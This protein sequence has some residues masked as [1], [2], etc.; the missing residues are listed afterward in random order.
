MPSTLRARLAA[1]VLT[2]TALTTVGALTAGCS[3]G[4]DTGPNI[5]RGDNP[6]GDQ[7]TA[8]RQPELSV[9]TGDLN[10]R[11]CDSAI[12][13]AYDMAAPSGVTV[14]CARYDVPADPGGSSDD[15]ISIGVMKATTKTTPADAPP[16][17]LTSGTDLPSSRTLLALASGDGKVLL[18][19]QPVVAVDFRGTGLGATVD[20]LSSAQR[21]VIGSGAA[22]DGRD[23]D[24]RITAVGTAA[25]AGADLC[26]D[27]LSPNQLNYSIDAAAA[28]IEGL[29][30]R[31]NV[32]RIALLG[33]GDGSS[34]ALRYAAAH[35]DHVGRLI[36][37]SPTGYNV[38]AREQTAARARGVQKTLT[39]FAQ[40]CAGAGCALG[41]DGAA[42]LTRVIGAG[43][44][45][46]L[47]G[48]SDVEV[49]DAVTTAI[50]VG[51]MSPDGMRKLGTAIANADHGDTSA[52]KTYVT[53]AAA[54]RGSD[55]R[56][57]GRCND[58]RGRPGLQELSGLAEDWSDDARATATTAVLQIA[59]CDGW[60]GTDAP[61]APDGLPVDPLVLV[62]DNDPFNGA[63]IVDTLTATL[64][65]TKTNPTSVTWDGLGFSVLAHSGCAADIVRD[66][67]GDAPLAAPT[68]RS[69]PA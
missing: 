4:P 34:V 28:D 33:I 67:M 49:L 47:G 22:G 56:L 29:R 32:D 21:T 15:S 65:G 24:A 58:L 66:Y 36:L 3:V 11:S 1:S 45:G 2:V 52:L 20:C 37:D 62:G 31:W 41:S 16:L 59:A 60:G 42:M 6:G 17:V 27:A 68:Q 54:V 12:S 25:R 55:G 38:A 69:C 13:K 57:V 48:I 9:P 51:D 23:L 40:R 14:V 19:R 61:G 8:P 50:A 43:A 39:T 26:S 7:D 64:A 30:S 10:W 44:S 18:D 5:V 46:D 35:D 53:A 63:D